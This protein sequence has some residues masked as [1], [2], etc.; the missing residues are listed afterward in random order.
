M[1]DS[2]NDSFGLERDCEA[3]PGIAPHSSLWLGLLGD[4]QKSLQERIEVY[5]PLLYC[6]SN[7]SNHLIAKSY[8]NLSPQ[9]I[10]GNAVLHRKGL[11]L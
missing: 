7:I 8:Q 3:G 6:S 11:F 4:V 1:D 2:Y 9:N 10:Y 5:H